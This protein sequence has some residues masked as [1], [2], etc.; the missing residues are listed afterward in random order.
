V[1]RDALPHDRWR[2]R[3]RGRI[4]DTRNASENLLIFLPIKRRI[5]FMAGYFI[6]TIVLKSVLTDAST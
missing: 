6:R 3:R 2:R 1:W 5:S 4:K